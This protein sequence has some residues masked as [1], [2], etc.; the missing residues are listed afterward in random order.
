[1]TLFNGKSSLDGVLWTAFDDKLRNLQSSEAFQWSH[2]LIGGDDITE[3][4]FPFLK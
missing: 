4:R 3:S 1:M 2:L